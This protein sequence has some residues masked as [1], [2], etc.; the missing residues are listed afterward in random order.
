MAIKKYNSLFILTLIS[1]FIIIFF[2]FIQKVNAK[3]NS[4]Q[5]MKN[6]IDIATRMKV[7]LMR[8]DKIKPKIIKQ[9]NGTIVI[10]TEYI[11]KY[12]LEHKKEFD[13]LKDKLQL[14]I[15]EHPLSSW[16]DDAYILL[17]ASYLT[18]N[19]Q[20]PPF[21][22]EA[23]NVYSKI[24]SNDLKIDVDPRI[25]CLI[26]ELQVGFILKPLPNE[27]WMSK[28]KED[29]ILKIVFSRALIIE[30]LKKSN[31]AKAELEVSNFKIR[32]DVLSNPENISEL[33]K[34]IS[35]WKQK[36]R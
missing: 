20:D 12:I 25:K 3:E 6:F 1:F 17:G 34:F 5:E 24:I 26:D 18:V 23:V 15:Q 21:F 8:V 22:N 13:I 27:D 31:F 10:K 4:R 35:V 29:E 32:N 33:E 28:L 19:L 7:F 2:I 16:F 36:S 30:Y 11:T 9:N 14:F